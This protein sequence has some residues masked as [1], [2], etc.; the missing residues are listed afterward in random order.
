[1]SPIK[2][3]IIHIAIFFQLSWIAFP[4]GSCLF[5][6]NSTA[7]LRL[8]IVNVW[9][10]NQGKFLR[11]TCFLVAA[12]PSILIILIVER[13]VSFSVHIFHLSEAFFFQFCSLFRVNVN[14]AIR[15]QISL[16]SLLF[17]LLLSFLSPKTALYSAWTTRG[18]H[19]V[20]LFK[21]LRPNFNAI[22]L[23]SC[24]KFCNFLVFALN[25]IVDLSDKMW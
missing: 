6:L 16:L 4:C 25:Q 8:L 20:L 5:P 10:S 19:F 2:F 3:I 21:V 7:S 24:F 1:M 12:C 11:A 23:F 9:T 15:C 14:F 18:E 22:I 13:I 17:L